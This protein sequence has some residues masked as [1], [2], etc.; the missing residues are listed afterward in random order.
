MIHTVPL[1]GVAAQPWRNGGG[2][3][4]ELLAWPDANDWQLRVSVAEIE[5][6]GP[7]SAFPGIERAFAVLEGAGVVLALPQGERRLDAQSRAVRFAGEAAP[8]CRLI[9]GPTRDLNLMARR[10]A[11]PIHLHR[12]TLAPATWRWR[13]LFADGTLWWTD[14]AALPWPSASHGWWMGLEAR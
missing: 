11:G 4:R 10:D 14:D 7:F 6:D 13:G 5:T 9:D 12:D 1:A 2:T 3:T 8:M